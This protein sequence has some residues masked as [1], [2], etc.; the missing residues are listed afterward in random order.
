MEEKGSS[1]KSN[2]ESTFITCVCACV[3]VGR[4]VFASVAYVVLLPVY[5]T[6]VTCINKCAFPAY[7]LLVIFPS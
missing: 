5:A 1:E 2:E 4:W 7:P 3:W 6:I